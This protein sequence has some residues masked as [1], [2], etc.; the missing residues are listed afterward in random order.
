LPYLLRLSGLVGRVDMKTLIPT[1]N[2]KTAA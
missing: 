2:V 1:P